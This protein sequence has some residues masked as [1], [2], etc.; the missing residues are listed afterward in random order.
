MSRL[1]MGGPGFRWCCLGTCRTRTT[2][3]SGLT[4]SRISVM[5]TRVSICVFMIFMRVCGVARVRMVERKAPL[6]FYGVFVCLLFVIFFADFLMSCSVLVH[7][8]PSGS[9][10]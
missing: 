9:F 3:L 1:T 10:V 5:I 8:A 7:P 6:S 2:I 4:N